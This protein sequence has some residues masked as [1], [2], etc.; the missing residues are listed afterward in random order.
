MGFLVRNLGHV[1]DINFNNMYILLNMVRESVDTYMILGH[2]ALVQLQK[3]RVIL[4]GSGKDE[5]SP[6]EWHPSRPIELVRCD[7]WIWSN[8]IEK[9]CRVFF[10]LLR[11][12]LDAC[13]FK[14]YDISIS[15]VPTAFLH[16]SNICKA[17][18]GKTEWEVFIYLKFILRLL[19]I[20]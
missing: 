13:Q 3:S 4:Y 20:F 5:R 1:C 16:S 15:C 9:I 10:M 6:V 8:L 2:I 7:A 19:D 12:D 18:W 14:H 17:N 11:L